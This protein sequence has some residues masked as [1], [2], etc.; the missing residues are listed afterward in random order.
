MR[1]SK[2][3]APTRCLQLII[4]KILFLNKLPWMDIAIQITYKILPLCKEN[5]VH[6]QISVL[7]QGK[8]LGKA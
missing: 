1:S 6:I 4:F 3:N 2:E 5:I 8:Y 7:V